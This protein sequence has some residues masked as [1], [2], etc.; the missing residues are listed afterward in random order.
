MGFRDADDDAVALVDLDG[1]MLAILNRH[2]PRR[3]ACCAAKLQHHRSVQVKHDARSPMT[4][5]WSLIPS[6]M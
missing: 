5:G 1:P 2:V 6:R 4:T 3:D